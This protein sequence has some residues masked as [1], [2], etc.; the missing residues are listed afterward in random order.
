MVAM[1]FTMVIAVAGINSSGAGNA[2]TAMD[3]YGVSA[4]HE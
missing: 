2:D 3:G 1:L 4:L